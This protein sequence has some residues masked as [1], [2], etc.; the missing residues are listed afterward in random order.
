MRVGE[1]AASLARPGGQSAFYGSGPFCVVRTKTMGNQTD[2]FMNWQGTKF[3]LITMYNV[4][5]YIL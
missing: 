4:P 1:T 3:H 2:H 5:T